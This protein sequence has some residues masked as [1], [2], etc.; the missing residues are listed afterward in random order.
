MP[1]R[2]ALLA[3]AWKN[4][5]AGVTMVVHHDRWE[6]AFDEDFPLRVVRIPCA[7]SLGMAP[8][9]DGIDAV[10]PFCLH[11]AE[12]TSDGAAGEVYELAAR[13]LLGPCCLAVHGVGLIGAG[14]DLFRASSA[15]LVW[16]PSSNL[17]LFGRTAPQELLREGIDVL[18]GSDSLLTGTGNLLDELRVARRT[19]LV[20][21]GRLEDAVGATAARRLGVP[22]A[23][24]R[25]GEPADLVVL[26]A[27]L[28]EAGAEHVE[29]VLVNGKP[30][31]ART[32]LVRAQPGWSWPG[33]TRTF[34][35]VTRWAAADEPSPAGLALPAR[36]LRLK[37][38]AERAIPG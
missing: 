35:G 4:L 27:P 13:G 22:A 19:G 26:S 20:S 1:R 9:L 3:G 34:A 32:E 30:R 37:S 18:L 14:I 8:S 36:E 28:L 16:C 33:R 25:P 21:D 11:L 23:A 6:P 17:F 29:L 15:A 2:E 12:G 10:R 38:T 24:L 31:V 7:D 5:F